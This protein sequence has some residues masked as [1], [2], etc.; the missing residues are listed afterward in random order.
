MSSRL[1]GTLVQ[2]YNKYLVI[3]NFF[4]LFLFLTFTNIVMC[5]EYT[6]VISLYTN[7]NKV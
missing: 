2:I 1:N 3:Q 5:T 6:F 7:I 4:Y